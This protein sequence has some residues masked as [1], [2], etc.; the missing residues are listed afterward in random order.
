MVHTNL[1]LYKLGLCLLIVYIKLKNKIETY[2]YNMTPP[3]LT[4]LFYRF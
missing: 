2:V 3:D 1:E 4:L